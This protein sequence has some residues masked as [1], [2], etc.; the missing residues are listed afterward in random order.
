MVTRVGSAPVSKPAI[1]VTTPR[2]VAESAVPTVSSTDAFTAPAPAIASSAPA[3]LFAGGRD[4]WF[5]ALD[6][7]PALR[8]KANHDA[9]G[10]LLDVLTRT[11]VPAVVDHDYAKKAGSP[12]AGRLL[13]AL[14]YTRGTGSDE[15]WAQAWKQGPMHVLAAKVLSPLLTHFRTIDGASL[16]PGDATMTPAFRDSPLWGP[17]TNQVGHF[18]CAVEAGTRLGRFA[19]HGIE[20]QVFE[21]GLKAADRLAG[22]QNL[23]GTVEDWSRAGIIGHEMIGD[24]DGSG[25]VG[26]M[27]AYDR[28]VANGDPD[29]VRAHWDAAVAAVLAGK[30]DE[31][32]SNIDAISRAIEAPTTPAEVQAN[33]ENDHP[34]FAAPHANRDGNSREDVALSVYGFATGYAAMTRGFATPQAL[35]GALEARFTASGAE[36]DAI[37]RAAHR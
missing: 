24:E 28:L 34:R 37:D 1:E 3:G 8:A 11:D 23:E 15:T 10:A 18:L 16:F 14:D 36:A 13:M 22:F 17:K 20:K 7:D 2:A 6:H 21:L 35:R 12:G 32:W 25:F 33:L 5:A 31:A 30:H 26:Q 27:K 4:A 9:I 29:H 19:H